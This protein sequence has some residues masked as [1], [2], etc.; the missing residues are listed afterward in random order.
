[1]ATGGRD[2]SQNNPFFTY[3]DV[4]FLLRLL[5]P[6]TFEISAKTFL[7]FDCFF[8]HLQKL[9]IVLITLS[10]RVEK[11]LFLQFLAF[12]KIDDNWQV[13]TSNTMNSSVYLL[14]SK[15]YW[16]SKAASTRTSITSIKQQASCQAQK[17]VLFPIPERRPPT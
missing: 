4:N 6:R 10:T 1:M 16:P 11:L 13:T 15:D 14:N 2:Y 5:F 12:Q 8:R 7:M 9:N 3:W 17:Y